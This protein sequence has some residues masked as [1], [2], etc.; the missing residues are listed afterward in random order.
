MKY[1]AALLLAFFISCGAAPAANQC[2]TK[3]ATYLLSFRENAGGSC[4]AM[5][6]QVVN[7][8][9]DGTIGSEPLDCDRTESEGC[10]QRN[11]NCRISSENLKCTMTSSTNFDSDGTSASGLSS[12][13]CTGAN[14]ATCAST[15]NTEMIRH[16]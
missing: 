9:A 14:G 1:I 16:E 3:G 7:I 4:G 15:Y 13:A 5:P 10:T 8:G 11:T 12:L 6:D 2:A